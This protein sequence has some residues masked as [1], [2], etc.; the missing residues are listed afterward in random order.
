M[1]GSVANGTSYV[2]YFSF[3]CSSGGEICT[4]RTVLIAC[5]VDSSEWKI[6]T[7]HWRD[8]T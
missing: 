4:L 3:C 5:T 7:E 6:S 1:P 2:F 8:N